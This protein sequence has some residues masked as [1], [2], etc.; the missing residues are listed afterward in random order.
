[1]IPTA[2]Q[3]TDMLD[4]FAELLSRGFSLDDIASIMCVSRAT[5]CVFLRMLREMMGEQAR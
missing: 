2:K 5:P 3:L 4:D 1:M